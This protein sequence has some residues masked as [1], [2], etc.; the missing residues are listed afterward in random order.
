MYP[1]EF[2]KSYCCSW[3]HINC[4]HVMCLFISHTTSWATDCSISFPTAKAVSVQTTLF[5][6][7]PLSL[8]PGRLRVKPAGHATLRK[9]EEERA[10]RKTNTW[11]ALAL[12]CEKK[13]LNLPLEHC[14]EPW[15]TQ[16]EY[17]AAA[18]STL[19]CTSLNVL[20]PTCPTKHHASWST[21]ASSSNMWRLQLSTFYLQ[22][23]SGVFLR[24]HPQ[25][26]LKVPKTKTLVFSFL[27][28]PMLRC[29]CL[30]GEPK[31]GGCRAI[32][33]GGTKAVSLPFVTWG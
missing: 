3:D 7:S 21:T 22:R 15:L 32:S 16:W 20:N 17:K 5:H 8:P 12:A 30:E 19:K 24:D 26:V 18:P 33:E 11:A 2:C 25:V 29:T 14:D 27:L 28:K 13:I 23:T 6:L 31:Q 10:M 1:A 4:N 9:N